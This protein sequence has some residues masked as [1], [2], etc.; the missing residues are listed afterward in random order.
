[1]LLRGLSLL[2]NLTKNHRYVLFFLSFYRTFCRCCCYY[3]FWIR[4]LWCVRFLFAYF[5]SI[6]R[7]TR[8]CMWAS[9]KIKCRKY[10]N[11]CVCICVHV[12]EYLVT[13]FL[14]VSLLRSWDRAGRHWIKIKISFQLN[15]CARCFSVLNQKKNLFTIPSIQ[16]DQIATYVRIHRWF[17]IGFDTTTSFVCI[18]I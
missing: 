2:P 10:R 13:I 12:Y 15:I 16:F 9:K 7:G 4:R 1:M 18:T 17:F 11:L 14:F 6:E 8:L 5:S 3:K